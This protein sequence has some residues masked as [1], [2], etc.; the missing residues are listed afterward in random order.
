MK[1]RRAEYD[2]GYQAA[3]RELRQKGAQAANANRSTWH[4][5]AIYLAAW[6]TRERPGMKQAALLAHVHD[7]LKALGVNKKTSAIEKLLR[8]KRQ[9]FQAEIYEQNHSE[10]V[11]AALMAEFLARQKN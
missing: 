7:D 2:A 9:R 3:L 11:N 10:L 6:W 4:S 5:H 8:D 1:S